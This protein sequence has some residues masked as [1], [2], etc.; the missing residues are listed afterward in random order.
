MRF[1]KAMVWFL[2]LAGLS[3]WSQTGSQTAGASEQSTPAGQTKIDPAKE[4]DIR[5]LMELLG[6]PALAQQLMN[7]MSQDIKPLIANSLPPGE[8]REKLVDLFFAKFQSKMDA[9]QLLDL[10]V[11]VYDKYFTQEEIKGLIQFYQTPLGKKM[12]EVLPRLYLELTDAGRQWGERAGQ[13][14]MREVL[15]E[16]PDLERALEAAGKQQQ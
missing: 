3:A 10:A 14:S 12:K 6:T 2:L 7:S 5:R 8:Y 11:P 4:A 15:A 13:E 9:K 1:H 16:H